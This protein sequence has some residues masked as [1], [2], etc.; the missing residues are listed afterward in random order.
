VAE[1]IRKHRERLGLSRED[2]AQECAKLGA[3]QLTAAAIINIE[4][5]RKNPETG[6]RRRE[7]S[8]DELLVFAYAMAV[9]PLQ[10]MFPLVGAEEVLTPPC[11]NGLP[12]YVA[13]RWATGEEAPSYVRADGKPYVDRSRIGTDGPTRFEAWR[14]VVHPVELNRRLTE[15]MLAFEKA[16]GRL[17]YFAQIE[18]LDSEEAKH[19][20]SLRRHH[21]GAMA[22]V[23]EEMMNAGVRTPAFDADTAAE[24]RSLDILTHPEALQVIKPQENAN[25]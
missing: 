17:A 7:V 4:V 2:L 18:E 6:K 21:R 24:L 14:Q 13:W 23:L 19:Q 15:E 8:V 16:K 20:V 12:P 11:W 10:L 9:P 3:P 22:M 25:A 1:Q 5:G